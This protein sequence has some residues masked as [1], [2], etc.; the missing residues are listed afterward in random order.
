MDNK[1]MEVAKLLGVEL[2]E[3]F[4]IMGAPVGCVYKLSEKGVALYHKEENWWEVLPHMLTLLLSGEFKIVKLPWKPTVHDDYY[5]PNP[6]DRDLW[7]CG[8]WVDND[9][10][11]NRF[12]RGLIVKTKEEAIVMAK[13]M[14]IALRE[15]NDE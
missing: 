12:S 10:D 8:I 3:E 2:E 11:N 15:A 9:N 14:L 4:E 5:Y 6:L 13:K 7:G 1:M